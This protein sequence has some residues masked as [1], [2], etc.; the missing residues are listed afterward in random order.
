MRAKKVPT[1]KPGKVVRLDPTIVKHLE[2]KRRPKETISGVLRRLI[3]LPTKDGALELRIYYALPSDL[4]ETVAEARGRAIVSAVR[5][6]KKR[7]M[8]K[9]VPVRSEAV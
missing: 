8:E 1:P 4:F 9:P 5:E 6:G 2:A 7:L 3:G